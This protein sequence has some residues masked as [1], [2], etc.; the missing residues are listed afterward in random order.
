MYIDML[1][2]ISRDP[3]IATHKKTNKETQLQKITLSL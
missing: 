3:Y 1:R 2:I